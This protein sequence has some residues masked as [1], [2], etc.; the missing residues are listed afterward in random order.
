MSEMPLQSRPV[1]QHWT[2]PVSREETL[3]VRAESSYWDSSKLF[4]CTPAYENSS[5]SLNCDKIQT[6]LALQSIIAQIIGY[7]RE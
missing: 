5:K 7:K 2:V 1:S 3:A 6:I 4:D